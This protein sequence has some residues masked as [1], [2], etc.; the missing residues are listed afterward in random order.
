MRHSDRPLTAWQDHTLPPG[1]GTLRLKSLKGQCGVSPFSVFPQNYPMFLFLRRV[2][3]GL[4]ALRKPLNLPH[5]EKGREVPGVDCSLVDCCGVSH[6]SHDCIA[7]M[8]WSKRVFV[9]CC[10]LKIIL[11]SWLIRMEPLVAADANSSDL[12]DVWEAS[13]CLSPS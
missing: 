3:P 10:C 6:K 1:R 13:Q 11:W 5:P 8:K 2:E 9:L 4:S 7:K 12:S